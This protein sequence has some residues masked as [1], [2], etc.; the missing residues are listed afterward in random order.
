MSWK[1]SGRGLEVC[2]CKTFCPCWLTPDVEP[3][4]GWCGAVLAWDCSE[5]NSEGV[6]LAGVKFAMVTVEGTAWSDPEIREWNVGDAVNYD[7]AWAG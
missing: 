2:N 4:E 5:G 7:F 1:V 6:D 3:D